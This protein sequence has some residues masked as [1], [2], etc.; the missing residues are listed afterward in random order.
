LNLEITLTYPI[1]VTTTNLGV[2]QI[3]SLTMT[4]T[5]QTSKEFNSFII[6][7][8]GSVATFPRLITSNGTINYQVEI[9]MDYMGFDSI[10]ENASFFDVDL[11][12]N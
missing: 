8:G 7:E 12:S 10:P 2:S 5:P 1:T 9:K 4:A 6:R 3:I 11:S